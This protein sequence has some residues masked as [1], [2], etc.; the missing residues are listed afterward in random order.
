MQIRSYI[1]AL[2]KL[3]Y[4]LSVRNV[5]SSP[6]HGGSGGEATR[7]K[8]VTFSLEKMRFGINLMHC[9]TDFKCQNSPY[10]E[11]FYFV[12]SQNLKTSLSRGGVI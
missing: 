11:G 4:F 2:K 1:S 8:I 6:K 3:Y 10:L 9:M 5:F 7:E 12:L